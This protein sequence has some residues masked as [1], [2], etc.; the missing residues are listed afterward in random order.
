MSRIGL[1]PIQIPPGVTINQKDGVIEVVGPKGKSSVKIEKGLSVSQEN[2]QIMVH[3]QSKTA[4]LSALSGLN[5]TLIQNAL[6]G[7]T[8]LWTKSLELVGVGFRAQ[9]DGATLTLSLGFSH[10]IKIIAPPAITFVVSDNKITVSGIDKYLVGEE[11]AK[12]RRYK[13][14]E[15]YKGKGI[16]YLGEI[17]RKK[18]GKATKALGGAP[19]GK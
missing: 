9:S 16:K 3:A 8:T 14:P 12:I 19:G 5:R 4:K 1:K 6:V 18:A 11:A 17:V 2:G 15:P 13:P 7:V 10:P